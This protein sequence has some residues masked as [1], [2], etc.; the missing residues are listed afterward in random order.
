MFSCSIPYQNIHFIS[1]SR[2]AV[3]KVTTAYTNHGKTSS[4]KRNNGQKPKLSARDHCTLKRIVTKNHRTTAANVTA[5]LNIH[6]GRLFPQ[7]QSDKSFTNPTSIVELQL[8][9]L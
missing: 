3:S 2:A 9:N 1:V 6:L 5:E 8:L 4:A 7:K